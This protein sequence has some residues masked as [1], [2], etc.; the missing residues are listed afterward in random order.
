MYHKLSVTSGNTGIMLSQSKVNNN[1]VPTF[2]LTVLSNFI[3]LTQVHNFTVS[4]QDLFTFRRLSAF[5]VSFTGILQLLMQIMKRFVASYWLVKWLWYRVYDQKVVSSKPR[6]CFVF[7]YLYS[8][9]LIS[10]ITAVPRPVRNEILDHSISKGWCVTRKMS[11]SVRNILGDYWKYS[12]K[13][14]LKC[15]QYKLFELKFS[16]KTSEE[17]F[18]ASLGTKVK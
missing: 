11:Q 7:F 2:I 18:A 1:R 17:K 8:I 5:T 9:R 3:N 12:Q 13:I 6:V 15:I 10:F 14:W 4:A 16:G